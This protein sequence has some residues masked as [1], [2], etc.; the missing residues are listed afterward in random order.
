[1][2]IISFSKREKYVVLRCTECLNIPQKKSVYLKD[3]TLN[4][5]PARLQ[6][7]LI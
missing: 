5:H 7:S 3:N 2:D 6:I 4:I 1:M